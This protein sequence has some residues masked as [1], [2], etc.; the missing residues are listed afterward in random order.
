MIKG[1]IFD[2][3]G[4][5]LDS[6]H[7][8]STMGEKYIRT[9]GIEPAADINERFRNL[10]LYEAACFYRDEYKV[11]LSIKEIMDGINKEA[12][13]YYFNSV[14]AKEGI[15]HLLDL[16]DKA[17]VKMCVATAT[18]R[19]QVEAALKRTGLDK[20]FL[21]IFTCTQVGSGK[22]KP[23]IYRRASEFL[24]TNKSE[25]V[26]FEDSPMALRTAKNDGYI[27]VGIF[28]KHTSDQSAL[29]K[30]SDYYLKNYSNAAG[31]V[32]KIMEE[33]T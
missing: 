17:G 12:E 1:A 3:D 2:L 15:D 26:V 7:I 9:L 8:W 18:D 28:D 33:T 20:F 10:T 32:K 21:D 6:M 30:M 23:F 4:T 22:D 29:K 5:L 14:P 25:T 31:F 24:K 19:Y 27:T 11:R 13:N 16:L